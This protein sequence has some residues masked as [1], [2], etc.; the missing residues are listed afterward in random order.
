M[1]D[2]SWKPNT[3]QVY[4]GIISS[5]ETVIYPL[6]VEA[7]VKI[8]NMVLANSVWLLSPYDTQEIDIVE[9]YGSDRTGEE[10]FV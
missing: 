1:L 5:K 8:D 3:D 6:Y 7:K 2:A 9:A 4:T 10:W